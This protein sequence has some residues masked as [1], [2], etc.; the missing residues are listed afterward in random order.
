[1]FLLIFGGVMVVLPSERRAADLLAPPGRGRAGLITLG[2]LLPYPPR[3]PLAGEGRG[4]PAILVLD[5]SVRAGIRRPVPWNAVWAN[6]WYNTRAAMG[7]SWPIWLLALAGIPAVAIWGRAKPAARTFLFGYLV[8]SAA[9]VCPGFFFRLPLLHHAAGPAGDFRRRRGQRSL[10]AGGSLAGNP[11]G[12]R[13]RAAVQAGPAGRLSR[14]AARQSASRPVA[15]VRPLVVPVGALLVAAVTYPVIQQRD[16]FF[17][18]PVEQLCREVYGANP[19]LECPAIADY[20]ARNTTADDRIAVL[21]SEPEVYFDAHR[22]SATGYIYTYGLM[23]AQPFALRM[24]EEMIHEIEAA[25]PVFVV[26]VNVPTSWLASPASPRRLFEWVGPYLGQ[27]YVP[28]GVADILAL[29][30]TE[31]RWGTDA[32]TYQVRSSCNV[33]VFRRRG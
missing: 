2:I 9:C 6:F 12:N 27:N 19:F 4:L 18:K 16:A 32:M 5:R 7:E 20:I 3:L 29:D 10:A 13:R 22:K 24:Q 11:Q 1:M 23:E 15:A 33:L 17:T 30:R 28:A 8:A 21:G 25:K 26:I 14:R 31:Y